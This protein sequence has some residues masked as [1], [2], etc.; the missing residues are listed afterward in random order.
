M[1][2][3]NQNRIPARISARIPRK[4]A[5]VLLAGLVL[6]LAASPLVPEDARVARAEKESQLLRGFIDHYNPGIDPDERERLIKSIIR[7]AR[8]LEVPEAMKLDGRPVRRLHFVAAFVQV[9][10]HFKRTAVSH[11]DARGYMQMMPATA[12]WLD[13]K[14]GTNTPIYRLFETD[15]NIAAGVTYINHLMEFLDNPRHVAL[16]YNAGPG[17]LLNGIYTERYWTKIRKAYREL[18]ERENARRVTA[19]AGAKVL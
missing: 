17:N 14:Y 16:A 18:G 10:S 15:T 9:E 4:T 13:Q 1:K 6:S 3:W 8:R 11:A 19:F 2:L 7:E 5:S 12:R